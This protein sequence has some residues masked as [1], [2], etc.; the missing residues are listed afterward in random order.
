MR[1]RGDAQSP[2][3]QPTDDN[4]RHGNTQLSVVGSVSSQLLATVVTRMPP[5]VRLEET[6]RH[7]PILS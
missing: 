6:V 5:Y 3:P 1:L 7:S 2:T 4:H